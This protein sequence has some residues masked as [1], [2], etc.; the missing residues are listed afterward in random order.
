M[1]IKKASSEVPEYPLEPRLISLI[2]VL[3]LGANQI[4]LRNGI[5]LRK[6]S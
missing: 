2:C 4:E 3:D 1:K 5:V 6:S